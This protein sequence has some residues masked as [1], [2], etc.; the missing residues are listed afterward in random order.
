[1]DLAQVMFLL[2]ALLAAGERH[3]DQRHLDGVHRACRQHG[4]ERGQQPLPR[5]PRVEGDDDLI[6]QEQARLGTAHPAQCFH[7]VLEQRRGGRT[8]AMSTVQATPT[9]SAEQYGTAA[10]AG[11]NRCRR[12]GARSCSCA[13]GMCVFLPHSSL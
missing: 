4:E 1:M 7:R 8:R 10:A 11:R 13:G 12:S 5:R 6:V 9:K 2:L 3:R